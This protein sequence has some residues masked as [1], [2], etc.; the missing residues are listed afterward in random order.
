M[1]TVETDQFK[2]NTHQWITAFVT[3]IPIYTYV[4]SFFIALLTGSTE[5][6]VFFIGCISNAFINWIL[7]QIFN[8]KKIPENAHGICNLGL[9]SN[10]GL[11][12]EHA[13]FAG[14][15]TG[16]FLF[17]MYVKKNVQLGALAGIIAISV[18]IIVY[19]L[20]SNCHTLNQSIVG[21]IIG[22]L[23]GALIGYTMSSYIKEKEEEENKKE[24]EK[25]EKTCSDD[26]NSDKDYVC[27]AFKNGELIK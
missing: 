11:P 8:S 14:F 9:S 25:N 16:Y 18:I 4:I 12:S 13:Q 17:Y 26:P 3:F 7:K 10:I 24:M 2:L 27:Q 19:R 15:V 23:I 22:L 21:Y 6:T 20:K 1:Q 5:T